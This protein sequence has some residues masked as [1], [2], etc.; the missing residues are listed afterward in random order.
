MSFKIYKSDCLKPIG[1]EDRIRTCDPH[2]PNV[3][4]YRAALLPEF[5]E[6]AKVGFFIM[7]ANTAFVIALCRK[8]NHFS[9]NRCK[10]ILFLLQ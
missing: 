8:L 4:R 6:R 1:R 9:D 5:F 10:R 2:V 7:T 3:V